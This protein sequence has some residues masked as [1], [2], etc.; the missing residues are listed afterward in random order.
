MQRLFPPDAVTVFNAVWGTRLLLMREMRQMAP[1]LVGIMR[2]RRC[3]PAVIAAWAP[4]GASWGEVHRY[5]PAHHFSALPV[6]GRRFRGIAFPAP[7]GDDTLHKSGHGFVTKPHYVRFGACARHISDLADPDANFFV[8]LGGQDGWLGSA[9]F[10]DQ[11]A[12]WRQGEYV[13]VPL[14]ANSIAE[15]FPLVT[16]LRG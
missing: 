10:D 3:M 7:G 15:R 12:L 6:L 8:L 1:S 16:V 9:N 4:A 2:W 14:L 11:V 13:Q 5:R